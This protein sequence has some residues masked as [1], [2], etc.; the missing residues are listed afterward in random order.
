MEDSGGIQTKYIQDLETK[1]REMDQI[2]LKLNR[3]LVM[4][5]TNYEKIDQLYDKTLSLLTSDQTK[6]LEEFIENFHN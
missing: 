2:N 4:V 6:E 3:K 1:V 5:Q